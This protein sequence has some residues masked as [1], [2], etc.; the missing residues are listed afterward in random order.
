MTD[1]A[2]PDPHPATEKTMEKLESIAQSVSPISPKQEL[3]RRIINV[4]KRDIAAYYDRWPER[5][6]DERGRDNQDLNIHFVE[7]I[8][9]V[10]DDYKI[11][12]RDDKD[13]TGG[14]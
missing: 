14:T 13:F 1:P 4:A 3:K 7:D 8:L 5:A 6:L 10:I 9:Q 11:G 12:A 2:T